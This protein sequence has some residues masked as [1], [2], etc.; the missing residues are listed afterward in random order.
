MS[1]N[2]RVLL[3]DDDP[4]VAIGV[5]ARLKAAGYEILTAANGEQGL[6][7]AVEHQPDTILLDVR[8]DGMDGLSRRRCNS[9]SVDSPSMPSSTPARSWYS[10]IVFALGSV[11]FKFSPSYTRILDSILEFSGSVSRVNTANCAIIFRVP[12]AFG[13]SLS[14]LLA[15]SFS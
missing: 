8:M 4:D 5:K 14:E 2:R 7:S 3:V 15:M 10:W 9:L 1:A 11:S 12:G 13:A 6:E